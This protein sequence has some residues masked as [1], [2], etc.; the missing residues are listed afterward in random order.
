MRI[1]YCINCEQKVKPK[2]DKSK[3]ILFFGT[4]FVSFVFC[5]FMGASSSYVGYSQVGGGWVFLGIIVSIGILLVGY[6]R[7]SKICPMCNDN[8]FLPQIDN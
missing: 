7:S 3:R 4:S 1:M 8:R 5:L 2:K 6:F